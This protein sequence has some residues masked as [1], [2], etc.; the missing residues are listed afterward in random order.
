MPETALA[1]LPDLIEPI[2]TLQCCRSS[3]IA[4]ITAL[5]YLSI[6]ENTREENTP[7]PPQLSEL[8]KQVSIAAELVISVLQH[9]EK[10]LERTFRLG[11]MDFPKENKLDLSAHA[12]T[13]KIQLDR[14]HTLEDC[15]DHC[16]RIINEW[17]YH[18]SSCGE[19]MRTVENFYE[20]ELHDFLPKDCHTPPS[21]FYPIKHMTDVNIAHVKRAEF[22]VK[23]ALSALSRLSTAILQIKSRPEV[24]S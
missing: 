14:F 2:I 22:S 21:W 13:I 7:R 15:S 10:G 24:S 9:T 6:A 16:E 17:R 3:A 23:T 4:V 20:E 5:E 18:L 11:L 12:E 8:R 1:R 19:Y